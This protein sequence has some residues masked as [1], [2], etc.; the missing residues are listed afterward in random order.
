E[1][2]DKYQMK[3]KEVCWAPH[4]FRVSVTPHEYNNEK[5]QRIT[6]RDV[7]SVDYSAESKHLLREISNITLSKK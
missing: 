5:R 3:L 7:A 2:G 6:V 1:G 4:L